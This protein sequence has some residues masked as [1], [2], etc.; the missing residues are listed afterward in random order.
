MLCYTV[1]V[2]WSFLENLPIAL[3]L[4]WLWALLAFLVGRC[5]ASRCSS[6]S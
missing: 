4:A 2:R 6:E 3:A 5:R 1:S